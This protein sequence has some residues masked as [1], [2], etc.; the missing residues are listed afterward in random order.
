MELNTLVWILIV[1]AVL[2]LW[3]LIRIGSELSEIR[4]EIGWIKRVVQ[5][6]EYSNKHLGG[7][8][9]YAKHGP[10]EQKSSIDVHR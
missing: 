10:E 1:V 8:H 5:E 3:I 9:Y 2:C 7:I 4:L 6:L